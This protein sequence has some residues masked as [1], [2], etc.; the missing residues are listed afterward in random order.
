MHQANSFEGFV[1]IILQMSWIAYI[2]NNQYTRAMM[3]GDNAA[4]LSNT[5]AELQP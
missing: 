2:A 3:A 1:V 4:P 5:P